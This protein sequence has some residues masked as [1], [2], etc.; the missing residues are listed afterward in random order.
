MIYLSNENLF[1]I[2][3]RSLNHVNNLLVGHGERVAYGVAKLLKQDGRFT[4]EER[5]V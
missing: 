5:C 3:I 2:T 1:E 4:D